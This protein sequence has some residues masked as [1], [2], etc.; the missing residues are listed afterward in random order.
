[1]PRAKRRTALSQVS[2]HVYDDDDDV[3]IENHLVKVVNGEHRIGVYAKRNIPAGT[4][5][6]LDYGPEFTFN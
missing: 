5:L 3:G 6:F 2:I 4:E 1:M